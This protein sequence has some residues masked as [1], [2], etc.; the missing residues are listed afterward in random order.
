MALQTTNRKLT[1]IDAQSAR[2][3]VTPF[4]NATR[5]KP[6]AP[7]R[8][9]GAGAG[10]GVPRIISANTKHAKHQQIFNAGSL[11]FI[12]SHPTPHK[13][14]RC[15]EPKEERPAKRTGRT[16]EYETTQG[17]NDNETRTK[18]TLLHMFFLLSFHC[19]FIVCECC[20][21]VFSMEQRTKQLN[22]TVE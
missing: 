13:E 17:N 1:H 14:S 21:C 19:Y 7:L 2:P 11:V 10:A 20:A 16:A 22:K 6:R 18:R 3:P 4:P 9:K 5:L 15:R 8:N 12:H